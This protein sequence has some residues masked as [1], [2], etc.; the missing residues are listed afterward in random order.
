MTTIRDLGGPRELLLARRKTVAA[1]K[2]GAYPR[3]LIAGPIITVPG[4][5]PIPVYGLSDEVLAVRGPDDARAK[6]NALIDA[7]ANVIKI[8]VSGRTDV[9]WPELSNE[10]IR[11]ITTAA[12]ARGVRVAAHIDRAVA[13]RRAVENG[14]DDAAHMPRDRMPDDLIRLLVRRN[15]ALIPTIDVY[16]ELAEARGAGAAWRRTTLPMMQDNLRRFVTAGGTLAL[17][18]DLGNPGV[19]LGMPM[20]EIRHW[21]RAGLSP[22]Q[23]IVAATRGSAHVC[24]LAA[25]LGAVRPGMIADLLVVNGD[26]LADPG[27]LERVT[28]VVH[29]GVIIGR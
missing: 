8:A 20:A 19:A 3:L 27:A 9:R 7:G 21:L 24:G 4:G 23:V 15:V 18:D 17:G 5:H 16:E 12:H 1:S 26:P 11:A 29:D 14:I 2:D 25:Q 6:V 13:L 28:L 22:M 10:E